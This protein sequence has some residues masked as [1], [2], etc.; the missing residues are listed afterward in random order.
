LYNTIVG[1]IYLTLYKEIGRR[2]FGAINIYS[3]Q[4]KEEGF[5]LPAR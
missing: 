4:G 3:K 5:E 2:L 1:R